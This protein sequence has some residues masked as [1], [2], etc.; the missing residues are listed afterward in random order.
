MVS[1]QEII[2]TFEMLEEQHGGLANTIPSQTIDRTANELGLDR[3]YVKDVMIA[4]WTM[5]G[6]G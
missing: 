1:K 4:Y 3:E 2:D 6:S 5:A